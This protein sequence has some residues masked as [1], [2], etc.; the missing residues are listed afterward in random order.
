MADKKVLVYIELNGENHFVGTLWSH[1]NR[2]KETSDFEYSKNWLN[3][4]NAFS[5]EPGL[6]FSAGKQVNPRKVSLFGSFGD[7]APDT[8]GRILMRRYEN[9]LAKDENRAPKT[10]NEID[11]LLYVNDFARQGALRFRTEE[12]GDFLFPAEIKSIPPIVDLAKLL[13]ASEKV[14]ALE[15]KDIDLQLLLAPGS[16]LGGARPKASVIDKNG[17]LCIAKFPKKDDYTNNVI[18][19]AVAL[20]LAR[21]CGL[22]TQEWS[23]EKVGKKQVIIMKRF[24]RDG[25]RRI[26][27]LSAMSMLNAVDN[28]SQIHS[29]IDIADAIRQYGATPKE[30]LMELWKRIVF[31]ILISNTDDHLR[32]HG[33]LYVNQKGWKLSPLYDVNP[34][35]DNKNVLSTYIT[36]N[37]NSQ[38]LDLVLSICDYFEIN[39]Q[40]SEKIIRDMKYV[41]ANWK[42]VA[43]QFSL[44]SSE[45]S[46]ME[47]AFKYC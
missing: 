12:N 42:Q 13:A 41:V 33:F 30:D 31:S 27:F 9:K 6:F 44:S 16:S 37:D 34:S 23:L 5:L 7:S 36:E 26:P 18:W 8:W 29:Y 20:T 24:D 4:K 46:K 2:G 43:K 28:D 38:S 3:N 47:C 32:N 11:Y 45:I 1:F 35:N 15:E 19:E 25:H 14:V 40:E 39:T 22:N 17:N 10:L 21:Q